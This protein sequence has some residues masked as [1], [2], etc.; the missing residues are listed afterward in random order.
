MNKYMYMLREMAFRLKLYFVGVRFYEAH[1][2]DDP[3]VCEVDC[4]INRDFTIHFKFQKV[5]CSDYV[6]RQGHLLCQCYSSYIVTAS[7]TKSCPQPM[8]YL[9][10]KPFFFNG[11]FNNFG[12]EEERTLQLIADIYLDFLKSNLGKAATCTAA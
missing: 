6:L 4:N 9:N 2:S 11:A 3:T 5:T 7:F 12:I 10:N 1:L 8:L